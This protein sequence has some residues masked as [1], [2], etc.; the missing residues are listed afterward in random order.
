MK[1]EDDSSNSAPGLD[2]ADAEIGAHT[3]HRNFTSWASVPPRFLKWLLTV[4][5]PI[6]LSKFSMK[7]ITTQGAKEPNKDTML[8]L[9]EFM[10]DIP[11]DMSLGDLRMLS[12]LSD[13]LGKRNLANG[14]RCHSLRLPVDWSTAG[15]YITSQKSP[16]DDIIQITERFSMITVDCEIERERGT[17]PT[18][19]MNFSKKRAS[20][21]YTSVGGAFEK[22]PIIELFM[23]AGHLSLF[24]SGSANASP[25][26]L[27]KREGD[28]ADPLSTPAKRT[29]RETSP[30]P[31]STTGAPGEDE[32][33]ASAR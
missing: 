22:I 24:P 32:A 11:K 7:A 28:D 18:V 25:G 30:Q 17:F 21:A 19:E 2:A 26:K 27:V 5:E 29:K 16:D 6:A 33:A 12:N 31:H 15:F 20:L 1:A 13:F 23:S 10:S 14:R 4:Q 9:I 3:L 8:E